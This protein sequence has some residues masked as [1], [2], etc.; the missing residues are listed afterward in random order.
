[1]MIQ[2]KTSLGIKII[3][4]PLVST[5]LYWQDLVLVGK[6]ALQSDLATHILLMPLLLAYLLYRVRRTFTASVSEGGVNSTVKTI[7]ELGGAMLCVLAFFIKVF[8]SYTFH[9]LEY[10]L[11]S[12]PIFIAGMVLIIFNARTLRVLVFPIIFLVFLIPIPG[13]YAQLAG[14]TLSII[15]SRGAYM[16]L[17]IFG[18]P[19]SLSNSY[20]SP[21]IFATTPTGVEI[22]F[23]IN[24]ACSG[25]HS[26][27]GFALFAVF[28]AYITKGRLLAK[29]GIFSLGFPLLYILNM[30]RITLLI[31]I[32]YHFGLELA[33]SAFHL[34]GG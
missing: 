26:L 2:G 18:L 31:I 14:A 12:L 19:V 13:E 32:G 28:I 8:G 9:P 29:I 17:R 24:I 11:A 4:V 6:E 23:S 22:P 1:M 10:H 3:M 20:G 21:V 15:S 7:V 5:I 34:L 16:L 33:T 30:M 27:I 25:L